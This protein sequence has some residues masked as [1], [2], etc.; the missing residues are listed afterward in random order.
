MKL[1]LAIPI[2]GKPNGNIELARLIQRK[3]SSREVRVLVPHDIPSYYHDEECPQRG[4][5]PGVTGQDHG[6]LCY[7]RQDLIEM[8][9]CDAVIMAPGWSHSR[10]AKVEYQTAQAI[11]M[12]IWFVHV[13]GDE[14]SLAGYRCA[15]DQSHSPTRCLSCDLLFNSVWEWGEHKCSIQ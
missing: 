14:V 15:E 11:G 13:D 1:Y 12:P 9:Q 6:G 8:L 7:L 10:G 5:Y 2:T 3:M 4:S